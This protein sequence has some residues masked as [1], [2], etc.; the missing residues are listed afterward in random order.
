V[1]VVKLPDNEHFGTEAPPL[2]DKGTRE[3]PH[4]DP[5]S[6]LP[7]LERRGNIVVIHR[8]PEG[9][10][11]MEWRV[12]SGEQVVTNRAA[13]PFDVE[14]IEPLSRLAA[15]VGRGDHAKKPDTDG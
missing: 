11:R 10:V 14:E 2:I 7:R 8:K 13:E 12:L 1:G 9:P 5:L 15:A 3:P 6:Y 4:G